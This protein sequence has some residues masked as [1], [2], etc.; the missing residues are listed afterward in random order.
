MSSRTK[1][2]NPR[3]GIVPHTSDLSTW[4][5]EVGG[6]QVPGQPGIPTY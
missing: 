3:P 2:D 1:I 6:W 5:A 4:E